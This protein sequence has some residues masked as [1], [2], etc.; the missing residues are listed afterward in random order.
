MHVNRPGAIHVVGG[1]DQRRKLNVVKFGE[2]GN[3]VRGRRARASLHRTW[4]TELPCH[5]QNKCPVADDD[6]AKRAKRYFE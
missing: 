5:M 1:I 4:R 6:A 3:E 2:G